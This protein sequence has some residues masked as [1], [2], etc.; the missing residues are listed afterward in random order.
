MVGGIGFFPVFIFSY[1]LLKVPLHGIGLRIEHCPTPI[2]LF[3][4]YVELGIS[5]SEFND[6]ELKDN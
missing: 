3:G 4:V 5:N 1:V 6:M 2:I